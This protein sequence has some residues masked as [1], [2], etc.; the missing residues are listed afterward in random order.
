MIAG[1]AVVDVEYKAARQDSGGFRGK[2][3]LSIGR[4]D[5]EGPRARKWSIFGSL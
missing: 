3:R 4:D 1:M 5:E 2:A